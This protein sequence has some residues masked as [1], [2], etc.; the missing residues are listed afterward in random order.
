[1]RQVWP[2][3]HGCC[4]VCSRSWSVTNPKGQPGH[5][6]REYLELENDAVELRALNQ[7]IRN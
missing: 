6:Q 7:G 4:L 3:L 2:T 1:M 5:A